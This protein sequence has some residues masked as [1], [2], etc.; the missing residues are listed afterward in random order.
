MNHGKTLGEANPEKEAVQGH[1]F[2]DLLTFIL[3]EGNKGKICHECAKN[4]M[5]FH[6]GSTKPA[7]V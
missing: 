5:T 4:G 3:F 2:G 1:R 7:Q 6:M